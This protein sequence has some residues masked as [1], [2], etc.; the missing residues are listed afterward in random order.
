MNLFY[1]VG[2]QKILSLLQ[3]GDLDVQI[4]AVKVVAN[5][6]AEGMYRLIFQFSCIWFPAIFIDF[7]L[8]IV[9]NFHVEEH[10][11]VDAISVFKFLKSLGIIKKKSDY[12]FLISDINQQGIVQEGG[13]DALLT[14]LES[15]QN[16]TILRVASGAIANLAMNGTPKLM[17]AFIFF[18]INS[19]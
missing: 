1:A 9:V 3:S 7:F 2:L 19:Y 16:T 8:R 11:I 15:S 13:L 12:L 10:K 17:L 14:L 5:L 6:A 18:S 4:H